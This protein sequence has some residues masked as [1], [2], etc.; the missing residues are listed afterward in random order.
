MRSRLQENA[1]WLA[2]VVCLLLS[3]GL[4]SHAVAAL[5]LGLTGAGAAARIATRLAV[6]GVA[7]GERRTRTIRTTEG[8][9]ATL[10]LAV[11]PRGF[12][13]LRRVTLEL[14]HDVVLGAAP[15]SGRVDLRLGAV[16]RGRYPLRA[17]T[18]V[19][20]DPLGLCRAAAELPLAGELIVHPDVP[21]IPPGTLEGGAWEA[22]A[23]RR[24]RSAAGLDVL[25]VREHAAGEP[26]RSVHW[27]TTARR[28]SLMV[29]E[30]AESRRVD[31]VVALDTVAAPA[32]DILD[33]AVRAAGALLRAI[34][35]EGRRGVLVLPDCRRPRTVETLDADWEVALDDLA[36]VK[37][38]AD[39]L[40]A[41]DR[42]SR[43]AGAVILVTTRSDG[44]VAAFASRVGATIVLVQPPDAPR[45]SRPGTISV[46]VGADLAASLAATAL[47]GLAVPA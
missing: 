9:P 42:A 22:G 27:P 11:L 36:G 33:T 7:G 15:V 6:R 46:A 28:G 38:G 16:P 45:A 34:V 8:I 18:L 1:A 47:S 13:T 39:V 10:E 23:R 29:R 5:G 40:A 19:A 32:R 37:A 14:A 12:G 30:L 21:V 20:N 24:L 3:F 43:G 35:A 25:G 4:G 2:G 44:Q 41:A 17:A 26:L 31:T